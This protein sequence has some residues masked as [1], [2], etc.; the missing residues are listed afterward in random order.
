MPT[1]PESVPL[2]EESN[3]DA[4]IAHWIPFVPLSAVLIVFSVYLIYAEVLAR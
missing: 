3:V 2:E 1:T 4:G